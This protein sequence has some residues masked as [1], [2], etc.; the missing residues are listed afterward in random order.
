MRW[1]KNEMA[2]NIKYELSKFDDIAKQWPKFDLL[3]SLGF[4][5]AA[6]NNI[7]RSYWDKQETISL[8]DV[9]E[10]VIS[11]QQ[12]PRPGYII[13]K[14][15]DVSMVGKTTLLN[16]LRTMSTI[17][18]GKKSN[19][20]WNQKYTQFRESHRVKGSRVHCWSFPITE[21]GKMMAKFRNGTHYSPRRRK[22]T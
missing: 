8:S 7:C 2:T 1:Q 20:V 22:Q 18:F 10:I 9:F 11:S 16:V 21:E 14:M 15:L 13:S 6:R 12:D 17:D 4:P 5:V 3:Y 19:L